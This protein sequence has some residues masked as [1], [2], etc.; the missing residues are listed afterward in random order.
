MANELK[1]YGD[2]K[3]AIQLITLK[4]KVKNIAG[5]AG[6]VAIEAAIDAAKTFIPGI[7]TA[8]TT[9][10]FIKAAIS[11][12]DTKKTKTWLDK[13]DIDDD[14]SKIIDNTVENGFM[15]MISKTI[16]GESDSKP[17]EQDFNM[18]Q[19]LV[20][21]LKQ[22][23]KGRTVTGIQENK[24][25]KMK[26]SQL[27]QLI[28]EEI[29]TAINEN[30]PALRIF[31]RT[32]EEGNPQI[33]ITATTP[34]WSDDKEIILSKE[35]ATEL[36]KL[37]KKFLGNRNSSISTAVNTKDKNFTQST[38]SI[39]PLKDM[40]CAIARQEGSVYKGYDES[41]GSATGYCVVFQSNIYQLSD[42]LDKYLTE[43]ETP[44]NT[45]APAVKQTA[46]STAYQKTAQK[47]TT[48][49]SK[50]SQIKSINDLPGAFQTWFDSLGLKDKSGV[51]QTA[52][53]SK[54]KDTLT[55]MG[56]K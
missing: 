18:N 34:G 23:Y 51:N 14:M 10:D 43:I 55:K 41:S 16:E 52:I 56:I 37:A 17:L 11:K 2:L 3:K 24:E 33:V 45:T 22:N 50:A 49:T 20:N 8:K 53:I 27:R 29:K 25:N 28:R 7:G 13:L 48:V 54:I 9:F 42:D 46:A 1:T 21:Y 36:Q 5:G 39:Q 30:V 44:Q 38:I 19:K 35:E 26:K 31:N 6:D 15:Q 32:S 40:K 47:A 12:P 4:Q